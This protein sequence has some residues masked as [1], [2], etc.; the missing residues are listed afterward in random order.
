MGKIVA[1]PSRSRGSRY[2]SAMA[3]EL[4]RLADLIERAEPEPEIESFVVI[5]KQGDSYVVGGAGLLSQREAGP[6]QSALLRWLTRLFA[7]KRAR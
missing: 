3:A 5:L 2:R 1:F 6:L 7:S 4:R